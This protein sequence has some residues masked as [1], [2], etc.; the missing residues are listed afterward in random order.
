[1]VSVLFDI[2][3]V[4]AFA[5]GNT[6]NFNE[7]D[8]IVTGGSIVENTFELLDHYPFDITSNKQ[9]NKYIYKVDIIGDTPD[10][11]VQVLVAAGSFQDNGYYNIES[12]YSWTYRI[13]TVLISSDDVTDGGKID[14]N[15]LIRFEIEEGTNF[16]LYDIEVINGRY[17]QESF[18]AAPSGTNPFYYEVSIIANYQGAKVQVYVKSGVFY[19]PN[20]NS[21]NRILRK[22]FS[23]MIT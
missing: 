21:Y 11:I 15:C 18:T 9:V 10:S 6:S 7:S 13:T 23:F 1:M 19:N 4:S 20:N 17:I 16:N 3:E 5:N 22:I 8:I 12:T 2:I 14:R